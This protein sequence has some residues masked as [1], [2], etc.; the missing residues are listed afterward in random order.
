MEEQEKQVVNDVRP[1]V[2]ELL[3]E[4]ERESLE[5]FSSMGIDIRQYANF[6]SNDDE[7]DDVDDELDEEVIG[8]VNTT[9]SVNSN[10]NIAT[11][12]NVLKETNQDFSDMFSDF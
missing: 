12:S 5:E 3:S 11:D 10:D 1:E 8:E 6:S 9:S 4:E 7:A 2:L